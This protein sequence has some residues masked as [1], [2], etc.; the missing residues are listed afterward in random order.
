MLINPIDYVVRVS[1]QCIR[2]CR[3]AWA[4]GRHI[5]IQ[6]DSESGRL[7]Q[8]A[9]RRSCQLV[10]NSEPA[11]DPVIDAI[12]SWAGADQKDKEEDVQD[13]RQVEEIIEPVNR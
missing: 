3:T 6:S 10:S 8:V 12:F 4:E 1:A 13:F 7:S 2:G 11:S 5:T 9:M